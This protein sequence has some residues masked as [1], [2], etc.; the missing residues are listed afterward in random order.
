[1]KKYFAA[2]TAL[3]AVAVI[4]LVLPTAGQ[5]TSPASIAWTAPPNSGSYDFGA[6]TL[7]QTV[8]QTFT[9]SNTGNSATGVLSVSLSGAGAAAFS[10]TLNTCKAAP[11]GKGKSCAVT[12]RY[13]PSGAFQTDTATLTASGKRPALSASITLTG[14][15]RV[16]LQWSPGAWLNG[17]YHF[18]LSEANPDPVTIQVT[19]N[20]DFPVHCG[21]PDGPLAAGSPIAVPV[22]L[23]PFTIPAGSTDMFLTASDNDILGWMGAVESPD[24][25]GGG[26][27]YNGEGATLDVVVNSSTHTGTINLQFHYLIPA[28]EN[29]PN[30]NCTDAS[31][32]NRDAVCTAPWSATMP[33]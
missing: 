25:C 8:S 4:A 13:T 17:G 24:L 20:V 22:S 29:E 6:V 19:G 18:W 11:L 16:V 21:G 1:M 2:A 15:G 12:V 32:P 10:I 31:D 23:A 5:A 33:F 3:A 26:A 27:M 28:A 9:L 14:T 30:T 7:G